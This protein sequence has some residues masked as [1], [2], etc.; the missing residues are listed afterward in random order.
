[1]SSPFDPAGLIGV[2]AEHEVDYVLVGGLGGVIHGSGLTTTDADIVPDLGPANLE[3][4]GAALRSLDA[5]VRSDADPDGV[6]FDPQPALLRSVTVLNLTTRCGDLDLAVQ[7]AGLDD[8][9]ALWRDAVVFE[10][11][12][13]RVLVASLADIIRSKRAADR[14]KD[15]VALPILVALAEEIE[16]QAD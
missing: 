5:R 9:D 3:R 4:L 11:A 6:G 12:G 2:L 14:P 10:L 16:Q 8:R 1:M 7:P 15:R 13:Q